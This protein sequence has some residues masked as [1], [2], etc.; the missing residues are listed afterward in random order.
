[1]NQDHR[2][3]SA[4]FQVIGLDAIAVRSRAD[5]RVLASCHVRSIQVRMTPYLPAMAS[6]L[7]GLTT[8]ATTI[9]LTAILLSYGG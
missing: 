8:L 9:S 7:M 2:I 1:M 6:S 4:G 3:A 5:R